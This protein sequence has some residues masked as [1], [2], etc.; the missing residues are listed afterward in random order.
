MNADIAPL[1]SLPSA[2]ILVVDDIEVNARLLAD[3]LAHEGYEVRT[4]LCGADALTLAHSFA[5]HLVLLDV[6]MPGMD[7]FEVCRRLRSQREFK[8]TPVVMVTALNAIEERVHGLDAGADDFV[9]KP[10]VKEE[11]LA[12]VRSLLRVKALYD[13]VDRQRGELARWSQTLEQRVKDKIDEVQRLS[14]LKRFFS[15]RLA[16]RMLADTGDDPLRSHR[17]EVSV[18][19]ADLRGFTA[20]AERSEP[21]LVM[22]VLGEFHRAM[23]ALIFEFEGTLERFTGDGM[24]VFFNDPDPTPDHT[25]RAARLAMAMSERALSLAVGWRNLDGPD[26]LAIGVSRGVATLGAIGFESRQDYAAIGSV[27][28]LAARLCAEARAGEVL[29]CGAVCAAIKDRTDLKDVPPLQ[30]K[31][32]AQ[33][34]SAFQLNAIEGC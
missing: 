25:L 15:P 28:N 26:G 17:Q 11:L 19:F 10:I 22:D 13:E 27:T 12:R 5:P 34:V 20:F 3:R 7:G 16:E 6:L 24:M 8:A 32:F 14:R 18:L 33:P 4:A 9:S 2:R 1:R 29:V 31:G 23:G 21:S 30:L